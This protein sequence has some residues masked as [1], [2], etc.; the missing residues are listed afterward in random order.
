[1]TEQIDSEQLLAD[2]QWLLEAAQRLSF[3]TGADDPPP[4]GQHMD[5]KLTAMRRIGTGQTVGVSRRYLE[6]IVRDLTALRDTA[7]L[8]KQWRERQAFFA[9]TKIDGMADVYKCFT[10]D[11]E[12]AIKLIDTPTT[13]ARE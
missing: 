13:K 5:P 7:A 4:V 1:M 12:A 9:T 10:D 8:V 11:L 3:T 2:V 6:A